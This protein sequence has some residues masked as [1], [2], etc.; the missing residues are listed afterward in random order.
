MKKPAIVQVN[1]CGELFDFIARSEI[2]FT[3]LNA[4]EKYSEEALT[5]S[6]ALRAIHYIAFIF[7]LREE[8]N[9]SFIL[10]YLLSKSHTKNCV[11]PIWFGENEK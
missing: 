5:I 2:A 3:I 11:S 6:C 1:I 4:W 10:N 7:H 9:V 8:E